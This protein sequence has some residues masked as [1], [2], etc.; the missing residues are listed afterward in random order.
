MANLCLNTNYVVFFGHRFGVIS[1]ILSLM[2]LA[3]WSLSLVSTKE[4]P[5]DHEITC[6]MT[7]TKDVVYQWELDK[8]WEMVSAFKHGFKKLPVIYSYRSEAYCNKIR[9]IRVRLEKLCP[10]MPI[11]STII[12]SLS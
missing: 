7:V 3:I 2:I 8:G 4:R 9:T 12:S 10:A 5:D 1:Y 11:A 6:F